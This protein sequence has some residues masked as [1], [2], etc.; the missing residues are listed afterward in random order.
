MTKRPTMPWR[1]GAGTGDSQHRLAVYDHRPSGARL[2]WVAWT[3]DGWRAWVGC[4]PEPLDGAWDTDNEAAAAVW[5]RTR[6][7]SYRDVALSWDYQQVRGKRRSR[8]N[9]QAVIRFTCPGCGQRKRVT[10]ALGGLRLVE[11]LIDQARDHGCGEA[12][13]GLQALHA[14]AQ[15]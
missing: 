14:S 12:R 15:G 6:P 10:D 3:F 9:V 7:P 8:R 13:A 1:I 2:G 5:A 11:R 4:S